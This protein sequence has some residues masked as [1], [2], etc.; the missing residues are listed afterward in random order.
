MHPSELDTGWATRLYRLVLPMVQ[1]SITG[2]HTG[3][4]YSRAMLPSVVP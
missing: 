2:A 3:G 4:W 1:I